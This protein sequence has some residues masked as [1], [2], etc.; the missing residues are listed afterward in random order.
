[1]KRSKQGFWNRFLN[2]G[3]ALFLVIILFVFMAKAA[4]NMNASAKVAKERLDKA[5]N[6]QRKLEDR[7]NDIAAK[8]EYLSTDKG[9]ESEIRS[10]FRLAEEGES[11]AVIVSDTSNATTV[12][13]TT[14]IQKENW[15]Q[16]LMGMIGF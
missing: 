11:V 4:W 16:K 2:S 14:G 7:K 15:W 6:D 5:Q 13:T 10:K 3:L 9:M 8:V 12:A 1:M